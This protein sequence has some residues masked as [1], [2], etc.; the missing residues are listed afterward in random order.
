[1]ASKRLCPSCFR[2][3]PLYTLGCRHLAC[4]RCKKAETCRQCAVT[5][6]VDVDLCPRGVGKSRKPVISLYAPEGADARLPVTLRLQLAEEL[7]D[8]ESCLLWPPFNGDGCWDVEATPGGELRYGARVYAS[9]FWEAKAHG[10]L[11]AWDAA[12]SLCWARH[13]VGHKLDYLLRAYGLNAREVTE[14]VTHWLPYMLQYRYV[15]VQ[16]HFTKEMQVVAPLRVEAEVP[17]QLHRVYFMWAG[18]KEEEPS[19]PVL[20]HSPVRDLKA[21]YV[22][23][24]GGMQ[25]PA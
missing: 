16:M 12:R 9:L 10:P 2:H 21:L 25:V 20:P 1:M 18:L 19:A 4:G 7:W 6:I 13:E 5:A 15:R 17:V 23:E 14:A 11:W 22:V 8:V 3:V 24:W